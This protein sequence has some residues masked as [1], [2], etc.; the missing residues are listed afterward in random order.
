M[1]DAFCETTGV[2]D[3]ASS[4]QDVCPQIIQA[5]LRG[6]PV[7]GQQTLMLLTLLTS[8]V[9]PAAYGYMVK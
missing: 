8:S 4:P 1:A 2:S 5:L 7:S 3:K 9:T 6:Q